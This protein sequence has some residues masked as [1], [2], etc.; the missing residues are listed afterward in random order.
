M[1]SPEN[2]SRPEPVKA[3]G[4]E[5]SDGKMLFYTWAFVSA[6]YFG[7]VYACKPKLIEEGTVYDKLVN[8]ESYNTAGAVLTGSALRQSGLPGGV[9]LGFGLLLSGPIEP[10]YELRVAGECK[11]G[12]LPPL[13]RKDEIEK[14]CQTIPIVNLRKEKFDAVSVGQRI[15]VK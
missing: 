2:G 9:G 13:D 14:N 12:K 8:G 11:D 15:F 7:G 1:V 10:R 6:L 4:D 5:I 3:P